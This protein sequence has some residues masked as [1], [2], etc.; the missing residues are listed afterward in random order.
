M[1]VD[2]A[3]QVEVHAMLEMLHQEVQQQLGGG[4]QQHALA[5]SAWSGLAPSH[6]STAAYPSVQARFV[7]F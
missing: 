4:C 6:S 1:R 5:C 2:F 3:C 7:T